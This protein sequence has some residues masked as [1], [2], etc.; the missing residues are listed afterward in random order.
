MSHSIKELE[1]KDKDIVNLV[2]RVIQI[3]PATGGHAFKQRQYLLVS[4][5]TG[6]ASLTLWDSDYIDKFQVGME[7]KL[8]NCIYHSSKYDGTPEII[9]GFKGFIE[10]IP[11][12]QESEVDT[13]KVS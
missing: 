13:E 8:I 10:V 11:P 2:C 5:G 3:K 7:L 9:T 1:G 6:A 4:D 12:K